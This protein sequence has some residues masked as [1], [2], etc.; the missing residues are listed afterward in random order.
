M[1]NLPDLDTQCAA[2]LQPLDP[3]LRDLLAGR[4]NDAVSLDL[5]DCT[6][7][8]VVQAGD[9]EADLIEALGFSPLV[10]RL[11]GIPL[12]P[13]WDWIEHHEGWIELVYT[14]GTDFAFIVFVEDAEG[15]LPELLALCRG[16]AE[17]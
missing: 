16:C 1:Y 10:S 6:H 3:L 9:T 12:L 8:V 11:D 17:L 13:D 4:I 5:A 14:M 2:L 7:F 15:V